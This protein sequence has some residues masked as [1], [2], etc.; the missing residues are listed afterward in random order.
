MHLCELK[1]QNDNH[2]R[3]RHRTA[4]R[5]RVQNSSRVHHGNRREPCG[6][7]LVLRQTARLLFRKLFDIQNLPYHEKQELRSHQ[8][9]RKQKPSPAMA[10]QVSV[11]SN[12]NL[13]KGDKKAR[14]PS[15]KNNDY[16]KK[17]ESF[18]WSS[19]KVAILILSYVSNNRILH[20]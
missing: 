1:L 10:S 8:T 12:S 17:M 4:Q 13:G 6:R 5:S 14:K 9:K 7:R 3:G 20:C 11:H 18:I 19:N 2:Q 16:H 15:R